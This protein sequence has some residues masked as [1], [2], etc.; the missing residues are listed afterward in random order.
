MT[1]IAISGH[2]GLS[3]EVTAQ[4]DRSIRSALASYDATDLVGLSC[5][6][7]GADQIFARAVL[8][9]GGQLEV[10]VPATRYR[11]A[12]PAEAHAAY[13]EL[14]G[15]AAVVHRFPQHVESTAESHMDASVEMLKRADLLIAVW[16]G[17]PSRSWGGTAD[18]VAE[19]QRLGLPVSVIWP[20][21]ATR[22]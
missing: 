2:R 18:V 15:H 16:D 7:D 6:A 11:E 12:L 3:R 17:L 19:A 21:G 4:V 10:Y 22:D 1:R 20:K 5:L 13:D 8:D 9:H 14:L